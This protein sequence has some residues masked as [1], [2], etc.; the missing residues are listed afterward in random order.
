MIGQAHAGTHASRVCP[1][2]IHDSCQQTRAVIVPGEAARSLQPRKDMNMGSTEYKPGSLVWCN[3]YQGVVTATGVS[4]DGRVEVS[5]AS[6][7]LCVDPE[8]AL[9]IRP[10]DSFDIARRRLET[11]AW[12]HTS[13]SLKSK[14]EDGARQLTVR[15]G[16]AEP[17]PIVIHLMTD[18]ELMQKLPSNVLVQLMS[19]RRR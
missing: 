15:R 16:D 19:E 12:R 10:R 6:G 2:S 5:L 1:A 4:P 8:D 14:S 18:V 17:T 9:T 7:R 13:A 3:G 11:L